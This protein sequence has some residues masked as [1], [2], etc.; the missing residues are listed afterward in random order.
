VDRHVGTMMDDSTIDE[1]GTLVREGGA[2]VLQRDRGGR[3]VL[4]LA[5][6]PVDHVQK[7]VRV[8]GVLCGEDRVAVDGV[9]AA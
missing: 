8:R 1:T 5:R 7:R 6:V 3:Y 9:S 2:F 4:E